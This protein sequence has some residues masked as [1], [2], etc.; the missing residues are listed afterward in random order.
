MDPRDDG[1]PTSRD[2]AREAADIQNARTDIEVRYP[3]ELR[4]VERIA[5]LLDSR[6][7]LPGTQ[8][9]FGLDG[10]LGLIPGVGDLITAAPFLYYLHLARRSGAPRSL[11]LRLFANTL[12]DFLVGTIPLV[13]DLFDFAFKSHERNAALLRRHLSQPRPGRRPSP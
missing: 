10:L 6:F 9:R 11:Q 3:D 7:R 2:L 8:M 4:R 5:R 13:G 1:P 12:I